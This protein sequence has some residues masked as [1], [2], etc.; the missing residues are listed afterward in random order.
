[1]DEGALRV[2][3]NISVRPYEADDSAERPLGVRTE[4]KNLNSVR[5]VVNA[6]EYEV[7]RQIAVLEGGGVIEN[8]TRSFNFATKATLS[9]RDKEAKQ[10]YRCR[11]YGPF[12]HSNENAVIEASSKFHRS[13]IDF[14]V[15]MYEIFDDGINFSW[16][17]TVR[18][19]FF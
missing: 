10:D 3:A 4:V 5:S 8:E 16:N 11:I 9:M 13:F 19:F 1:M 14:F 18:K 6:I 15:V 12:T 7:D 17:F 2:D